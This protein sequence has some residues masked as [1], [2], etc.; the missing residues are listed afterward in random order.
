MRAEFRQCLAM[1][2]GAV[3]IMLSGMTMKAEAQTKLQ[4][5]AAQAELKDSINAKKV[6]PGQVIRAKLEGDVTLN[7]GQELTKDTILEGHVDQVQAS[8]HRSD[9][10]VVVTFDKAQ[11]KDGKEVPLKATVTSI[12]ELVSAPVN[13]GMSPPGQAGGG[14]M[15]AGGG[16]APAGGGAMHGSAAPASSPM[17]MP[18][19]GGEPEQG[20]GHASGVPGVTLHSD[21]HEKS[22]ATFTATR[23]NVDVSSGTQMEFELVVIPPGVQIQ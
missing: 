17:D 9:S 13:P 21:I 10:T 6:K 22:S 11:L 19:G 1:S 2:A 4:M 12:W 20:Q 23:R 18:P 15:G 8:E 7:N 14:Q 16:G 3:L 5:A